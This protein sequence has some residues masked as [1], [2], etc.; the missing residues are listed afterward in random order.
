MVTLF[1][2]L[3]FVI[4]FFICFHLGKKRVQKQTTALGIISVWFGLLW[5]EK[6]LSTMTSQFSQEVVFLMEKLFLVCDLV[7]SFDC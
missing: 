7:K 4:C 3:I 5:E 2:V 6:L 1:D